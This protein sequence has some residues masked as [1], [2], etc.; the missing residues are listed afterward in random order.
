MRNATYLFEQPT[1]RL[2][3]S[4]SRWTA[5]AQM[6]LIYI[7]A[8]ITGVKLP[9]YETDNDGYL[10]KINVLPITGFTFNNVVCECGLRKEILAIKNIK[11][12]FLSLKPD[13][14]HL[15]G[16]TGKVV[17]IEVKTLGESVARNI[18][19]Y[20]DVAQYISNFRECE[21]YYLLSHGHEKQQDWPLLSNKQAQILLWEDLFRE[22]AKTPIANVIGDNLSGY[23]EPP[24][25]RT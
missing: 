17:L 5:V 13:I 6:S 18:D 15:N 10:K 19:L 25:Q 24:K 20:H 21:L 12:R 11:E 7:S 8:N 14:L 1:R 16:D 4:E 3:N 9:I 22:M 2:K 23:C